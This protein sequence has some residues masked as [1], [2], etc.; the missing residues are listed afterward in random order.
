ML[1]C[2]SMGLLAY[3]RN[4]QTQHL[5]QLMKSLDDSGDYVM[6]VHQLLRGAHNLLLRG[7]NIRT[8]CRLALLNKD[9]SKALVFE[10][11]RKTNPGGSA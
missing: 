10:P 8:G 9:V 4:E 11:D 1:G 6:L 3:I 7:T 2:L 5:C